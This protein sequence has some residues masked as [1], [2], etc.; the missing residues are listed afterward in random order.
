MRFADIDDEE[1]HVLLILPVQLVQGGNLPPERRSGIASE[2]EH[3]R[4]LPAKRREAD[5]GRAI[6]RR[7]RE[8]G[9]QLSDARPALASD[10]PT[11]AR[12]GRW[13]SRTSGHGP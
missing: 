12:T 3:D 4:L 11:S 6:D 13:P 1:G 5:F 10:V 8:I 7:Q 2:H 9:R